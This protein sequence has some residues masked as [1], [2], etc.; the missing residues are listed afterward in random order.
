MTFKIGAGGVEVGER[1]LVVDKAK[2]H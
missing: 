1:G 2:H